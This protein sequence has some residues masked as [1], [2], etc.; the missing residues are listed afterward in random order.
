MINPD[1]VL[2]SASPRRA[3]LLSQIGVHFVVAPA[4]IDESQR[5]GEVPADYVIRMAVEKAQAGLKQQEGDLPV[6]GADTAVVWNN[7]VFG[8]PR[9]RAHAAGM[10]LALSADSHDVLS[11]VALACGDKC[12]VLLSQ[13]KV[14]FRA[15][16]DDERDKYW[17]T[18]EPLGKAGGYAIQGLGAVFVAQLKGSYS[19]VV[20]LPIAETEILLKQFSIPVWQMANIN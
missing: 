13:T 11:A 17:Q 6:L 5:D 3:E 18:G 10:L 9:D 14:D 8:K 4:D 2:A 16:S 1:I 7:Q 15:I 20:G 12:A 19:G